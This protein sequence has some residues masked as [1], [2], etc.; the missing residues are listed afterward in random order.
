MPRG[1]LDGKGWASP[2]LFPNSINIKQQ[3]EY[4]INCIRRRLE[5][6]DF[7]IPGTYPL[8]NSSIMIIAR[9]ALITMMKGQRNLQTLVH[10]YER[11]PSASKCCRR[12]K[13][14][15]SNLKK[16]SYTRGMSGESSH[17][18]GRKSPFLDL[19]TFESAR[20]LINATDATP[21]EMPP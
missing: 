12:D 10:M 21:I 17:H 19:L 18:A 14:C 13:E 2:K 9:I 15:K 16:E 6:V 1:H 20:I 3:S 4:D 7:R 8:C 5:C 11:C